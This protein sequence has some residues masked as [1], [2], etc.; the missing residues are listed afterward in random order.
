MNFFVY[1][2]S[3]SDIN[4][5]PLLYKSYHNFH[6]LVQNI[7]FLYLERTSFAKSSLVI[8]RW[9]NELWGILTSGSLGKITTKIKCKHTEDRF[10]MFKNVRKMGR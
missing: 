10:Q 3:I 1:H 2:I 9:R 7:T 4:N 8:S 5:A 6:K